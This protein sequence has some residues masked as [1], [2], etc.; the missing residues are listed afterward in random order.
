[1]LNAHNWNGTT[2]YV[3]IYNIESDWKAELLQKEK[4]NT[5]EQK[6]AAQELLFRL[7]FMSEMK[8]RRGKWNESTI[9]LKG[10]K[11]PFFS[12]Y[13]EMDKNSYFYRTYLQPTCILIWIER[14][15][16]ADVFDI[17]CVLPFPISL[18]IAIFHTKK[19][20]FIVKFRYPKN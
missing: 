12:G 13:Y 2:I 7:Q 14:T 1:M 18:V 3:H 11:K 17:A 6:W 10:K 20:G 19:K 15:W 8:R 9:E 5:N 16:D 4:V